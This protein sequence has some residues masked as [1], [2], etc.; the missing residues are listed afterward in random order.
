MHVYMCVY[1]VV[2]DNTVNQEYF[3]VKIFSQSIGATQI[4]MHVHYYHISTWYR[5]IPMKILTQKFSYQNFQI[6]GCLKNLSTYFSLSSCTI[7]LA[8]WSMGTWLALTLNRRRRQRQAVCFTPLVASLREETC[9][10]T[11]NM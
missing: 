7:L 5:V 8:Y 10:H 1:T 4:K 9:I 2:S 11:Y 6:Y 3:D